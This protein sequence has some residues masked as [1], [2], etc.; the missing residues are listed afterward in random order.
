VIFNQLDGA[1][2]GAELITLN[3]RLAFNRD[4]ESVTSRLLAHKRNRGLVWR[5][6]DPYTR[7][8]KKQDESH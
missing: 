5:Q 8:R 4:N 1:K 2:S 7:E 3:G 6:N